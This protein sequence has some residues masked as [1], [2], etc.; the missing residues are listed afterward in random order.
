VAQAPHVSTTPRG[1]KNSVHNI[2]GEIISL[3]GH[4]KK[5]TF[6]QT[7]AHGTPRPFERASKEVLDMGSQRINPGLT[8]EFVHNRCTDPYGT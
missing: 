1:V 4:R 7:I 3:Y 8:S 5:P 2:A 6:S